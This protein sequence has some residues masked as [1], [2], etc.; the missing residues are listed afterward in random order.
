MR[1]SIQQPLTLRSATSLRSYYAL[2]KMNPSN[3]QIT[4]KGLKVSIVRHKYER[5]SFQKH[6]N[7][8]TINLFYYG[9]EVDVS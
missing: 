6:K 3:V 2:S 9:L 1:V 8:Y 5:F 4:K 7:V